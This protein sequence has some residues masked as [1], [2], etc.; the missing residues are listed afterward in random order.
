MSGPDVHGA[1]VADHDGDTV[2][3]CAYVRAEK[4]AQFQREVRLHQISN[5]YDREVKDGA[6]QLPTVSQLTQQRLARE[7]RRQTGQRPPK[8][9]PRKDRHHHKEAASQAVVFDPEVTLGITLSTVREVAANRAA[10]AIDAHRNEAAIRYIDEARA[11]LPAHVLAGMTNFDG[12]HE[13]HM[14]QPETEHELE[15]ELEYLEKKLVA[16]R[17]EARAAEAEARLRAKNRGRELTLDELVIDEAVLLARKRHTAY[18]RRQMGL[19]QLRRPGAKFGPALAD[20]D[21]ELAEHG[22]QRILSYPP[23]RRL[24]L[25]LLAAHSPTSRSPASHLSP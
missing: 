25:N 20:F 7:H 17:Q 11:E 4:E 6:P 3:A 14:R 23:L 12:E 19:F 2:A 21:P 24:T 16:T 5:A 13:L 10:R 18:S 1:L 8:R 15:E 22:A 9:P